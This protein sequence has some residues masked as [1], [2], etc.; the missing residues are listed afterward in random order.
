[1]QE[2]GAEPEMGDRGWKQKEQ[3][4]MTNVAL[5]KPCP[6]GLLCRH[7]WEWVPGASPGCWQKEAQETLSS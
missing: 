3:P 6:P 5:P 2:T 4:G 7:I 1:M